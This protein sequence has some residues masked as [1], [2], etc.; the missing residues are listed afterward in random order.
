M[1]NMKSVRKVGA[2]VVGAF[3]LSFGLSTASEAVVVEKRI[4]GKIY[5]DKHLVKVRP[6]VI[7]R[8]IVRG[9]LLTSKPVIV[10]PM[11]KV[12]VKKPIVVSRV[13]R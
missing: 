7:E 11:T 9:D 1:I 4:V 13:M 8:N 12:L 10:H 5:V 3:V 2:I 6:N